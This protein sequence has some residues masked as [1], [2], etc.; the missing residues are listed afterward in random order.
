MPS[1]IS[2]CVLDPGPPALLP[3]LRVSMRSSSHDPGCVAIHPHL[4]SCGRPGVSVHSRTHLAE[5]GQAT[6]QA[7]AGDGV[8]GP[9][10]ACQGGGG[11]SL[12]DAVISKL[13]AAAPYHRL[14]RAVVQQARRG[15][16]LEVSLVHRW[17]QRSLLP[18]NEGA[19]PRQRWQAEPRGPPR[20]VSAAAGAAPLLRLRWRQGAVG[21]GCLAW[22]ARSSPGPKGRCRRPAA[23]EWMKPIAIS[24]MNLEREIDRNQRLGFRVA[25]NTT[26]H[27]HLRHE[28]EDL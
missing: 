19:A 23:T 28:P 25:P 2:K 3:P 1:T 21:C 15:G 8:P 6:Q 5:P 14:D 26:D 11:R 16:A 27:R 10:G 20:P 22:A 18:M 17:R 7:G 9:S 24:A 12:V 4:R 13:K